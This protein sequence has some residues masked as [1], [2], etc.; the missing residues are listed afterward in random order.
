MTQAYEAYIVADTPF[1]DTMHSARTAGTSFSIADRPL[2]DGW[3]FTEQDDW[4]VVSAGP[5]QLP[6]QGW[7][8][9]ASATMD[10][11]ERALD[12]VWDYCVLRGI[13]FKFLRSKSALNARVSKYVP[14]GTAENSS[15]STRRTTPHAKPFFAS[16]ATSSMASRAPMCSATCAGATA[17]PSDRCLAYGPDASNE[18]RRS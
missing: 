10:N 2:P 18:A 3:E 7:K 15:P 16:S 9:H 14:R 13:Q 17:R 1:Y 6:M 11:A 5:G 4:L 8:I 12:A